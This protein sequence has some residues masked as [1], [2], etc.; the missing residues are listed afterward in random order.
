MVGGFF[1]WKD[2]LFHKIENKT[3]VKKETILDLAN[4]LAKNGKDEKS[5]REI[6]Q[7]LSQLTGKEI[8]KEKEEEIIKAILEDK[9]PKNIDTFF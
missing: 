1:M 8:S 7:T 9:V 4:K 5:I 2:S 6:I 3:K